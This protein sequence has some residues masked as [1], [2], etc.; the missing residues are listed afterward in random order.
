[1]HLDSQMSSYCPVDR[2]SV[3]RLHSS[4]TERVKHV[5]WLWSWQNQFEIITK[6]VFAVSKDEHFSK[7]IPFWPTFIYDWHLSSVPLSRNAEDAGRRSLYNEPP[8]SRGV[9]YGC[10]LGSKFVLM[11]S[12]VLRTVSEIWMSS[13]TEKIQKKFIKLAEYFFNQPAIQIWGYS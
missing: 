8:A 10:S 1:M 3:W 13:I 7:I 4:M 9:S 11:S 5:G 6:A 12:H 2:S